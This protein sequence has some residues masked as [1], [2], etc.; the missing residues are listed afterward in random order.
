M[1]TPTDLTQ[2]LRVL[3]GEQLSVAPAQLQ[4]DASLLD[5]LGVDSLAAIE[6]GMSIEDV[7]GISLPEDSWER[8]LTYGMVEELVVR[9][10]SAPASTPASASTSTS[11]E[12]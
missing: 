7:F 1:T 10:A 5:D 6:W 12:G 2:R 3:S 9:L 8:V 4:P 11:T